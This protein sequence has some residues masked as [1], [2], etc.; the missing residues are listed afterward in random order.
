METQKNIRASSGA[1]CARERERGI[2]SCALESGLLQEY[3]G[4][5]QSG[6]LDSRRRLADLEAQFRRFEDERQEG[7]DES[8]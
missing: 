5:F 6:H 4:R 8:L 7:F 2:E 1:E 3:I